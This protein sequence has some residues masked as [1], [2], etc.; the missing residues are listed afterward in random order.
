MKKPT[1]VVRTT[2]TFVVPRGTDVTR[3]QFI[4]KGVV[5]PKKDKT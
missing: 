2:T 3:Q 5:T 1:K 4:G